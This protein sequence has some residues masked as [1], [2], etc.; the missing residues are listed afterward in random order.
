MGIFN[1]IFGICETRKPEDPGCWIISGGRVEIDLKRAGEFSE[2]GGAIRLEGKDLEDKILVIRGENGLFYAYKN[3]CTH[4]GR[5]IDPVSGS[6][7]IKCCSVMGSRFGFTGEVLSGPAKGAL[8]YFKVKIEDNK[9]N[10]Y[11]A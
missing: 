1:K 6:Q 8:K 11:I 3:K 7:H 4:M 5:R 2:R 9:L 10:I